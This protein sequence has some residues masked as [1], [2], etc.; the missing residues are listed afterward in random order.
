MATTRPGFSWASLEARL[1]TWMLLKTVEL[2]D[3]K[4]GWSNAFFVIG[5]VVRREFNPNAADNTL[6]N[7]L[8]ELMARSDKVEKTPDGSL[9]RLIGNVSLTFVDRKFN[10]PTGS[11]ETSDQVLLADMVEIRKLNEPRKE[12][13]SI[14]TAR[15]EFDTL[16]G[17][18]VSQGDFE[19]IYKSLQIKADKARLQ[20]KGFTTV[21]VDAK[22]GVTVN[23]DR[24]KRESFRRSM[25]EIGIGPK[26]VVFLNAD[27][28]AAYSGISSLMEELSKLG[29]TKISLR[30]GL[31]KK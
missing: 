11:V 22:G 9:V 13:F 20:E 10:S 16:I 27:E 29:V 14:R 12:S 24:I 28:G 6:E 7:V 18:I 8:E 25:K 15:L 30:I 21:K 3:P 19:I 5:K 26:S 23:G 1:N 2:E 4:P 17:A 31:Q